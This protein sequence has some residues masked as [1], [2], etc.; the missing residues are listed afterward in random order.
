M[1]NGGRGRERLSFP[2]AQSW[3]ALQLNPLLDSGEATHGAPA[4]SICGKGFDLGSHLSHAAVGAPW[5]LMA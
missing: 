2:L 3:A 4:C 5:G 1:S